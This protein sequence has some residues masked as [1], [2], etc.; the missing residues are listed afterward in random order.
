[1][2]EADRCSRLAILTTGKLVANDTPPPQ[3]RIGGDVI[4]ITSPTQPNSK[5][6]SKNP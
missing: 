1:M 6:S 2:D 3:E 5:N 4:T